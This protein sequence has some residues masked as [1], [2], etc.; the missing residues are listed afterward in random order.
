MLKTLKST[1]SSSPLKLLHFPSEGPSDYTVNGGGSSPA[2]QK[3]GILGLGPRLGRLPR[4]G[5]HPAVARTTFPRPS[6]ER[7]TRHGYTGL[8]RRSARAG[9]AKWNYFTALVTPERGC[10]GNIYG[11]VN[12]GPL[13]DEEEEQV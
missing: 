8:R 12:A 3:T 6:S 5:E 7:V 1:H 4:T 9:T 10:D 11:H 2:N 13:E